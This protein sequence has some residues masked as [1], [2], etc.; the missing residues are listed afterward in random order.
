MR[1]Q[2]VIKAQLFL[3][4]WKE[5]GGKAGIAGEIIARCLANRVRRNMG[6]WPEVLLNV[7]R[8]RANEPEP[9]PDM[10]NLW[11][12]QV[13]RLM[14]QIENVY[15]NAG[16]DPSNGGL[17]WCF[18]E[19]G[20]NPWFKEFVIGSDK[21]AVTAIQNSLKVWGEKTMIGRTLW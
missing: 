1:A 8:Y 9:L 20:A 7:P 13:M 10:P 12:P 18:T 15:D 5:S 17:Y 14:Q 21:L 16:E 4:A 6:N 19:R 2:D 11:D 3:T